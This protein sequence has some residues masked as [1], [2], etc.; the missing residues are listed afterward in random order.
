MAKKKKLIE[1]TLWTAKW[2]GPCV[3]LKPWMEEH[4]PEVI[5]KDIDEHKDDRPDDLRSV[6]ALHV[7]D[8]LHVGVGAIRKVL[9]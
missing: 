4:H 3:I 6:P 8:K 7:K 9:E 2:C 5:I 1:I